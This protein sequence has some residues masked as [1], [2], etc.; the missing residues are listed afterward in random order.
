MTV[1]KIRDENSGEFITF[2]VDADTNSIVVI[3]S[4]HAQIHNGNVYSAS[5]YNESVADDASI[6]LLLN[7]GNREVHFASQVDSGGDSIVEI[8]EGIE[9]TG[10][11]PITI[12]NKNRTS[13]NTP[14]TTVY[15][16]PTITTSGTTL[17]NA[18]VIGG[19]KNFA[20][21]GNVR[22]NTEWELNENETY[23]IRVTNKAGNAQAISIILEMYEL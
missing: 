5:I 23:A 1:I 9:Y 13:L 21:G 19:V 22:N 14:L 3:D 4:V 10:G 16:N 18:F 12:I 17:F 20:S 7:T 15:N 6:S 2:D 8:L 11:T